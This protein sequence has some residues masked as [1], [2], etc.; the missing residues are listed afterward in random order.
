[1]LTATVLETVKEF[2]FGKYSRNAFRADGNIS[3][4]SSSKC[5][6]LLT[7]PTDNLF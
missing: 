7:R 3:L 4:T 2:E 1:M 6:R 5:W